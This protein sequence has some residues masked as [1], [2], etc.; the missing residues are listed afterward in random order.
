MGNKERLNM[1]PATTTNNVLNQRFTNTIRFSQIFHGYFTIGIILSYFEDIF[2]CKFAGSVL[3]S[4]GRIKSP[5]LLC[6]RHVFLMSSSPEMFWIDAISNI[7]FMKNVEIRWKRSV[8][9]FVGKSV[10]KDKRPILSAA[11]HY[12]PISRFIFGANPEPASFSFFNF[13]PESF[14]GGSA[15]SHDAI[16][17]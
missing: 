10:G 13:V 4:L 12:V 6:I 8:V 3:F 15:L 2:C 17:L 9:N 5:L 16:I 7:A 11:L 14:F 1:F